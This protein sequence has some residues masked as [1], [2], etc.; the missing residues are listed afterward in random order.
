MKT[1][2][3][4]CREIDLAILDAISCLDWCLPEKGPMRKRGSD[5]I[6]KLRNAREVLK[7]LKK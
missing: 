1:K 3:E 2:E 7:E 5:S 4:I 6:W